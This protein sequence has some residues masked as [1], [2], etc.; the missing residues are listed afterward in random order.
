MSYTVVENRK[1]WDDFMLRAKRDMNGPHI[2]IG[3]PAEGKV[4]PPTMKG[5]GHKPITD[6]GKMATIAAVHEF[7]SSSKNI[8]SRSFFRTAVRRTQVAVPRMVDKAAMAMLLRGVSAREALKEVGDYMVKQLKYD[9]RDLRTPI[10]KPLTRKRKGS[11]TLL[12][13]RGQLVDSIQ[14]FTV[15]K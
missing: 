3:F 4:A 13:D 7:G 2:K 8:P 9:L 12:V 5:S 11:N 15:A 10:L 14:H 1:A 6:M